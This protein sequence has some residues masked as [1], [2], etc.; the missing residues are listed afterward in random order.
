MSFIRPNYSHRA[1]GLLLL[2]LGIGTLFI[3]HGWPKLAGGPE[4]WQQLG[5]TMQVVGISFAPILWGFLAGF[6]EVAGGFLLLLG[7]FW[8]PACL[9][10]LF[11]MLI[12]IAWHLTNGDTFNGYAHALQ[13]AILFFS[14]YFIGPGKHSLDGKLFPSDKYRSRFSRIVI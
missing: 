2:R 4:M 5:G 14:L 13:S 11:T 3:L 6:A 9:L 12:A 10:L 8:R 1:I 7:L